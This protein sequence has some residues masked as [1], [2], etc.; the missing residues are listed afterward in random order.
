M[1]SSVDNNNSEDE[2][3]QV[4]DIGSDVYGEYI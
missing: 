4:Q 3:I 1:I 2:I